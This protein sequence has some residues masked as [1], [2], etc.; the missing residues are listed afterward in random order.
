M[1]AHFRVKG[2]A[3]C[4]TQVKYS[5]PRICWMSDW[6]NLFNVLK[7]WNL[8]ATANMLNSEPAYIRNYR[9]TTLLSEVLIEL[10]ALLLCVREVPGTLFDRGTDCP[11]IFVLFLS[12]SWQMLWYYLTFYYDVFLPLPVRHITWTFSTLYS[13]FLTYLLTYLLH[14]TESFLRSWPVFS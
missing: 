13:H 12:P 3:F 5:D 1:Q 4:Y 14:G 9:R 11:E 7:V 2:W 8:F 10:V 6:F